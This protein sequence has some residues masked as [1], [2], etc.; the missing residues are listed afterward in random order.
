MKANKLD[1]SIPANNWKI[2]EL[3]NKIKKEELDPSPSF[4][5]KLVWKKAHKFK[6]IETILM[7]FPFPEIYIAPGKIDTESLELKDLIVDGQQRCRAIE[8]YIENKDVF[9]LKRIPIKRFSELSKEEKEDF[10][11][12]EVSIRYLKNAKNEQIKEIFQRINSTEYSLNTTE[13]LNAQ[14]GES[15]FICFTKQIV[16]EDLD[17]DLELINYKV[18]DVNREKT[19]DFFHSK[20]NVFTEN[21]VNRMLALQYMLTLIATLVE[22][23]Y[24]RR[25]DRV[26]DLIEKYN[27]EFVEASDIEHSLVKTIELIKKMELSEKSYWFNKANVFT[28]IIELYKFDT[29]SIDYEQL[30]SKLIEFEGEYKLHTIKELRDTEDGGTFSS[31]QIKYFDYAREAVNEVYAREFRGSLVNGMIEKCLKK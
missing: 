31:D 6:F 21:D 10:L 19:L 14:W 27:E 24:F 20:Y 2:I 16:E 22:G 5:R 8:S 25:N 9:A 17:V 11:N 30:K 15:E 26:Q 28:L 4:Q 12:Y 7:N 3:F 13:R 29:D 1:A 23:R 18:L